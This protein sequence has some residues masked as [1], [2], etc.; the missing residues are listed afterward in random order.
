METLSF[1]LGVS[2]VLITMGV[3]VMF[4]MHRKIKTLSTNFSYMEENQREIYRHIDKLRDESYS[5]M[6]EDRV[7]V[8]EME[9]RLIKQIDENSNYVITPCTHFL[10]TL[11]IK[12]KILSD[13]N[14]RI[15]VMNI[16]IMLNIYIYI[17]LIYH[18]LYVEFRV[19]EHQ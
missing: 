6:N 12:N 11:C 10:H 18:L 2:A 15:R 3:V 16:I 1:M 4:N 7:R 8:L 13:N 5:Q 19:L 9:N 17:Y 14:L